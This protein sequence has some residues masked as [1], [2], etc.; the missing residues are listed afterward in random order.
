VSSAPTEAW[1]QNIIWPV[2]CATKQGWVMNIAN[3]RAVRNQLT[4]IASKSEEM[5]LGIKQD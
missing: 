4:L 5:G 2:H 3:M 1:K